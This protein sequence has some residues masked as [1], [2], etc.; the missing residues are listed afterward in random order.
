M[1]LDQLLGDVEVLYLRGD[2][3]P[4][5]TDVV[6]VTATSQAVVPGSLFCCIRGRAADGHDFAPAAVASGAAALLCE[7]PLDG[8][9]VPQAVV[10]D[11]RAAMA[12]AAAAI[13]HHPSRR[14]AVVGVT[15][16]NG[17]TPTTHL[18]K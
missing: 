7:R 3:G 15:G 9:A 1:R 14:V 2:P 12:R 16:T 8:L 18:L 6:A 11:S 4:A 17:K 5:G 13:H 10:A